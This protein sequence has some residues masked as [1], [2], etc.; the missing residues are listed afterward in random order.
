[1]FDEDIRKSND[2]S[3]MLETYMNVDYFLHSTF[4]VAPNPFSTLHFYN[5]FPPFQKKKIWN[6]FKGDNGRSK[7]KDKLT[8]WMQKC[9]LFYYYIGECLS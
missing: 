9:F 1:M 2:L 7:N 5:R 8:Q 3:E 4:V 6:T